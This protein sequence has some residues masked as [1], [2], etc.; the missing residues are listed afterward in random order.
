MT[1]H[2]KVSPEGD[3]RH[4]TIFHLVYRIKD[5]KLEALGLFESRQ[6]AEKDLPLL[7]GDGWQIA[8]VPCIGWGVVNDVVGRYT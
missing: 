8:D 4:L 5:G 6:T 3:K 7:K 2:T 1:T